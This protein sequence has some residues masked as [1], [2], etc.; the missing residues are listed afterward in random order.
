MLRTLQ[1]QIRDNTE[2]LVK[3]VKEGKDLTK[4]QKIILERLAHRQ[5]N[6]TDVLRKFIQNLTHEGDPGSRR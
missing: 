4:V 5:G 6:V 1:T 3:T 2:N